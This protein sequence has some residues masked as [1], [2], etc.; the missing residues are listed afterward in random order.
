MNGYDFDDIDY[1]QNNELLYKLSGQVVARLRTYLV[2]EDD[3]TNVLQFNQQALVNLIHAQMQ[4]HFKESAPA[5]EAH[6]TKGF[7]VLRAN[8]YS[9]S[10]DENVRDFRNTIPDGQRDRI[11]SMVFGGFSKCLYPIQK[12][13][14]DSERRFAVILENDNE[15]VKWFKP[16]KGD[17]QIHYSRDESYEP[18]FVVETKTAKFLCEPK[19]ASEMEDKVVLAK[20]DA[21]ITWCKHATTHATENGGKPWQY[22]LIPHD[23]VLDNMTLAGLVERFAVRA[24]E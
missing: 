11:G 17:F 6:V 5:Y 2:K 9:A 16:A 4:Q 21:A 18:D 14:S 3:V 20:A 19:Q 22:L 23:M 15:V 24:A 1:D 8:N 13:D 10:A 7:R 12:F